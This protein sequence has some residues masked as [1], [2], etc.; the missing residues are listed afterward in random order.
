MFNEEDTVELNN[1]WTY[2]IV[3]IAEG[4]NDQVHRGRSVELWRELAR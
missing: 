3:V 4:V 2:H 1:G